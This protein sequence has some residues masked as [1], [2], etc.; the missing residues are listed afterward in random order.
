MKADESFYKDADKLNIECQ[1][2]VDDFFKSE[3]YDLPKRLN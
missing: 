1:K 2:Y 3:T